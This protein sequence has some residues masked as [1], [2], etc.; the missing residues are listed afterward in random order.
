MQPS[1]RDAAHLWDM[2]QAC[3]EIRDF[4]G[5]A[6][7]EDFIGDR[8]LCLAVERSLEIVGEAAGK[9]S[10]GFQK[11]AS[12]IS[13][14]QIRSMRNILVHEYGQIDYE[15]VYKTV[16]EDIPGL[17]ASLEALLPAE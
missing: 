13:W 7:W 16:T 9:V 17:I 12:S 3:R 10:E 11:R 15:I 2:L 14:R 6:E 8:K 4:T 5:D 1:E